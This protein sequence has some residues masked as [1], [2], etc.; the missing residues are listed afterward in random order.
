VPCLKE[1]LQDA[2]MFDRDR[3]GSATSALLH[4]RPQRAT[5]A[6]SAG[7]LV[8]TIALLGF[9]PLVFI[10]GASATNHVQVNGCAARISGS[11]E[12]SSQAPPSA[13]GIP[14]FLRSYCTD[15]VGTQLPAGW[16]PFDGAPSGDPGS[17]FDP[18]HVVV[19][20]GMLSLNTERSS[21]DN[22]GWAT[23]GVCQCGVGRTYGIYLVRSRITGPG[24]DEDQMLWP[25]AHVWPPEVDFNETGLRLTKTGWYVHFSPSNKQI[26]R[27][28]SIDLERWHTWGVRWTPTRMVFTVDGHVW[29]IVRSSSVIPHE[30]MT[31]DMSQQ[32]WCAIQCPTRPVSMQVDWVAEYSAR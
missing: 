15:F 32:T 22:G 10:N 20:N 6:A 8:A 31:L 13:S 12:P 11:A 18:S 28:L 23:G 26:A 27:T 4:R 19:A 24:D 30:A 17:L 14:G 3:P 5:R 7:R 25:A 9:S 1:R 16:E 29:G 21:S 2:P